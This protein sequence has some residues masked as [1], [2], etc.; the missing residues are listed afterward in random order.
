MEEANKKE[1]AK[2]L[3]KMVRMH[4]QLFDSLGCGLM[5]YTIPEHKMLVLNEEAKKIF[6]FY[7]KEHAKFAD[8]L[9]YNIFPEDQSCVMQVSAKLRHVG[10]SVH[11]H[12]RA[13][14]EDGGNVKV[15]CETKLLE[16]EDGQKAILSIMKDVTE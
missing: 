9:R 16:F 5:A 4:L 12:F 14:R 15:S 7:D 8:V 13:M 1:S 11:Y 2:E 6:H 10:D 3:Q